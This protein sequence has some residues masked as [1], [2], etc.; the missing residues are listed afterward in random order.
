MQVPSEYLSFKGEKGL[1]GLYFSNS[2]LTGKPVIDKQD[3]QIE[4]KWTL[5]S[6][7]RKNCNRIIT[8]LNGKEN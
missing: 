8:I 6:P 2:N 3:E 1:R 5:Y 4:F 7:D